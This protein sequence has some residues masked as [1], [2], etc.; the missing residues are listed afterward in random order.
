MKAELI[1]KPT[2]IQV[3][4]TK[5]Y[6]KFEFVTGNR[7]VSQIH[8]LQLV[9]AIKKKDFLPQTPII[10]NEEGGIIDGQHR[11][12]ASK[13]LEKPIYYII[14]EKATLEDAVLLNTSLKNWGSY[15]YFASWLSLN[16]PEY[17]RLKEFM[18]KY[19]F[20]LAFSV[21][22]LTQNYIHGRPVWREMREG[23]FKIVD[24]QEAEY[25]ASFLKEFRLFCQGGVWMQSSFLKALTEFKETTDPRRVIKQLERHRLEFTKRETAK[26]YLAQLQSILQIKNQLEM[27]SLL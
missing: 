27:T 18:R 5:E 19:E 10:I 3:Y 21:I 25:M 8:V 23:R 4:Q 6:D 2:H 13:K 24:Y 15:D 20:S 9:N 14:R 1:G 26:E 7:A 12:L 16:K 11:L 22:L 17:I